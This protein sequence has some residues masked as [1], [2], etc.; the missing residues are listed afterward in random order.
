MARTSAGPSHAFDFS[1]A[2]RANAGYR[3]SGE[4]H[5]GNSIEGGRCH[6]QAMSGGSRLSYICRGIGPGLRYATIFY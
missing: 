6:E 3:P 4:A 2:Y 5:G 1:L